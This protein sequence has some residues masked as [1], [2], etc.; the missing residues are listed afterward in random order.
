MLVLLD[1]RTGKVLA[2]PLPLKAQ[3]PVLNRFPETK[4]GEPN[5][6]PR[7]GQT[8][9]LPAT[10]VGAIGRAGDMDFFR[11]EARV[12]Q[13]V[14]VQALTTVIG[15]RLNPLL[16][17]VDDAGQVVAESSNGVLGHTCARAGWYALGIRDRDYRG[18]AAMHY[19]LHV[20]AVPVVTAVFPLGVQRGREAEISIEGVHLGGVKSVRIQAPADAAPGTR[21]PLPLVGSP[22]GNPSVVVGAFADVLAADGKVV[23]LP[24]E[25]TANGR[26]SKPGATDTWRF[27]ARK[28]E[29]LLL[30]I[31]ARRLGSPLDSFIEILDSKGKPVPWVT[32]RSV[33]RT[34]S[35]FRDHDSFGAGIRIE[36]WGELAIN[37]Y[38]YTRGELIRIRELPKNPDDDCQFFSAGG[39]R[40]GYFGTTPGQISLGTPMYKVTLHPPGTA[41]PPSG[42]PPVTLSYRNDDGGAAFGKDSFLSFD[43]SADGEYQVRVGEAR[44]GRQ[45]VC[46]SADAA[47]TAPRLHRHL[48]AD[49]ACGLAGRGRA[50]PRDGPAPRWLRRRHRPQVG[51]PAARL[52]R[53]G[54][55]HPRR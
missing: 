46:L 51:E 40:R 8:V 26:I 18:G 53:S 24:L 27:A 43:P 17:L 19:R 41:F 4:E 36:T 48:R 38:L 14:G 10:L 20:G 15:S 35:T 13:Q 50:R 2:Q 30:E 39:R 12:G 54:D 11:F 22:L 37:D 32:L 34:Y 31:E 16:N 33:A 25:G 52:Q 7:T 29:R 3:P 49:G 45:S 55:E 23:T 21:L 47:T 28:G 1:T 42:F 6:S 9:T 5:D 44:P